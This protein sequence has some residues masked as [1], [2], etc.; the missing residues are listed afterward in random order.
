MVANRGVHIKS[1]LSFCGVH[2]TSRGVMTSRVVM[3]SLIPNFFRDVRLEEQEQPVI[4]GGIRRR[5]NAS[6]KI[7]SHF[8]PDYNFAP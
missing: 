6:V 2:V 7:V 5:E 3:K 4:L 8:S 1:L